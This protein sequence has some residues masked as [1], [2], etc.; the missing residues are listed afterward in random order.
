MLIGK[1]LRERDLI[2]FDTSIYDDESR[3]G[4][5]YNVLVNNNTNLAFRGWL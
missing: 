4:N 2:W 5:L 3:N 1:C